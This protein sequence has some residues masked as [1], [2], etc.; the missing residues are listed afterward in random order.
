MARPPRSRRVELRDLTLA[1]ARG[2]QVR[3]AHA[4]D[5]S[6]A[7]LW[8]SIRRGGGRLTCQDGGG[9]SMAALVDGV[10][11]DGVGVERGSVVGLEQIL[12]HV[13]SIVSGEQVISDSQ[14]LRVTDH[15][16]PTRYTV[17][18]ANSMAEGDDDKGSLGGRGHQ[19]AWLIDGWF[20]ECFEKMLSPM[21]QP[22]S[23]PHHF[24]AS[25]FTTIRSLLVTALP[26]RT[27]LAGALCI[28][29]F[30]PPTRAHRPS[31]S[32][33]SRGRPRS[34]ESASQQVPQSDARSSTRTA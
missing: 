14:Q 10:V 8:V 24:L 26:V 33:P 11:V 6:D 34:P 19:S 15:V 20:A 1:A 18:V 21:L 25:P 22:T 2:A 4:C 27:T 9:A 29:P 31:S 13:I 17:W 23:C 5:M 3:D 16:Y 32:E 30:R 12:M 28:S 7:R